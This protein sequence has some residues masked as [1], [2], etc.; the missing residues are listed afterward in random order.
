[1][2]VRPEELPL[3]IRVETDPGV[4]VERRCFLKTAAIALGAVAVPGFAPLRLGE[5]DAESLSLEEFIAEV[6][7]VARALVKDESLAGQDRYLLTVASYAVRLVDVPVPEF[8]ESGQGPGAFIGSNGAPG[9]FVILHWKMEPGAEIRTHPHT[10]GNVV[11]LGLEGAA[12]VSNFEVVGEPDYDATDAFHVRR[13]VTQ[14]LTPGATNL[15]N[16]ER[17]SMHGFTTVE[18]A[19]GLDITTRLRER[20]E[21]PY[22]A[23]GPAVGDEP[24]VFEASWT[25]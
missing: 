1:M 15:V 10:Y 8:R 14:R 22:L 5:T 23:L 6:V 21:T 16:L 17:N 20:R 12:I 11:T 13:T 7:P 9:P 24:D 18:G 4:I 2:S 3:G 25:D 19:R